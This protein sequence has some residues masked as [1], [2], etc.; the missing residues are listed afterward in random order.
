MNH[1]IPPK[2]LLVEGSDDEH[3]VR[4]IW[5]CHSENLPFT[6]EGGKGIDPL[7][8]SIGPQLIAR[9]RRTLGILADANDNPIGRWQKIVHRIQRDTKIQMPRNP[10]KKT[11]QL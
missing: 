1:E 2:V 11:E 8:D 10:K 5:Q 4:H 3:V 7:L 9:S 6:V